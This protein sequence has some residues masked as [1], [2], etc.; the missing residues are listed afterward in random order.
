[1][2]IHWVWFSQLEEISVKERQVLLARFPDMAVLYKAQREDLRGIEGLRRSSVQALLNKDLEKARGILRSCEELGI[3]I[4]PLSDTAYPHRLRHLPDPPAVLYCRGNMPDLESRPAIGVVGTRKASAYGLKS[5]RMLGGQIAACGGVV[6]SGGAKG[7]DAQATQGAL[8]AGWPGIVILAGGL[9]SF[10]PKVNTKLFEKMMTRGCLL[11][12]YP[13]RTPYYKWNFLRRNRLISGMADAVLVV[14]APDRSGSLNTANWALEQGRDV[15]VVPGTLDN[16]MCA[17]S[18][19]LLEEG[20][21]PALSGWGILSEYAAFYPDTLQKN[22]GP[23]QAV[24]TAPDKKDIDKEEKSSYSVNVEP[25]RDLDPRERTVLQA[26][27]REPEPVDMLIAKTGLAPGEV[28]ASLTR[29][30]V[31]GLAQNH[32]GRRVSM[33]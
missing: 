9:D 27:T 1:M 24:Q 7:I 5:A 31:M 18:N 16:P 17:G 15:F 10:Y 20:A 14:E 29:L 28:L 30:T 23:E 25:P 12:E 26:L 33:K 32:P 11:S 2:L 8:D 19:A 22:P 21:R 6:V 13:P 3:R 4:I